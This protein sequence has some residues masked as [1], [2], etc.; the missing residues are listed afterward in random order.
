LDIIFFS[1]EASVVARESF[2]GKTVTKN[3]EEEEEEEEE[4]RRTK[5]LRRRR[6]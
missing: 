1:D 6:S 4:E 3:E 5:I 2:L